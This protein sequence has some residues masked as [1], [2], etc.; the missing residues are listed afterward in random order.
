[1]LMLHIAQ[2]AEPSQSFN[3]KNYEHS[4]IRI[5]AWQNKHKINKSKVIKYIL[6]WNL[7]IKK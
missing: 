4:K 2:M 3:I 6:E 1:M 5:K 7:V